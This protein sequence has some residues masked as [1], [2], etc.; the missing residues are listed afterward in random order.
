MSGLADLVFGTHGLSLGDPAPVLL[1]TD[2]DG[3][4]VDLAAEYAR[5]PVYFYFFVRASTP[6]CTLHSCRLR[7]ASEEAR[8]RGIEV[9]GVSGDPPERLKK[10]AVRRRL[11]FRLLSDADGAIA[12]G[13]GVPRLLGF[14]LRDAFL[15]QAGRIVW[16]GHAGD[17][18][19]LFLDLIEHGR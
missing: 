6:V 2:Q 8:A 11:P 14:R 18:P 17:S 3:A 1:A 15:V 19:K 7:D 12:R 10:F 16:K 13:F 4:T 5:G 9:F